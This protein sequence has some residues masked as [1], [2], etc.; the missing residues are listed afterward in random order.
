[1]FFSNVDIPASWISWQDRSRE[2]EG[3][4]DR[5]RGGAYWKLRSKTCFQVDPREGSVSCI[6]M[7]VPSP[8]YIVNVCCDVS[9][10]RSPIVSSS[11]L[12][13]WISTVEWWLRGAA[14]VVRIIIHGRYNRC[15]LSYLHTYL[16][17]WSFFRFVVFKVR[18][19]E[20]SG[21]LPEDCQRR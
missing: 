2:G 15:S 14:R 9:V 19:D 10:F 6:Y 18:H 1:M 17:C 20:P 3:E 13:T 7:L 16:L 21:S 8:H 11:P 4:G 12:W 5:Q